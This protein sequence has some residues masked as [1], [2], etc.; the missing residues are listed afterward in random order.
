MTM[1]IRNECTKLALIAL[2]LPTV[3]SAQQSAGCSA[4]PAKSGMFTMTHGDALRNVEVRL[5]AGYD[6]RHPQR[7]VIAFHAWTGGEREFVGEPTVVA[8]SSK[9]GYIL[10]APRGLGAGPPDNKWNGWA[11]RGST[12]GVIDDGKQQ[13]P[14]C[15][16][17]HMPDY[18]YPSCHAKGIAVNTCGW[19][20]CQ[21]DDVGF[22]VD[23][24][25]RLESTLCVDQSHVYAAGGFNGG[26]FAW[27]VGQNPRTAP[28]FRAI[29]SIIGVPHRGDLRP[30]GR[31]GPMPAILITGRA[32][33]VV[34]PGEWDD[35]HFTTSTGN[36]EVGYFAGATAIVQSWSKADNCPVAGKEKPFSTAYASDVDC[37]SYCPANGD[38]WPAV[39]DCRSPLGHVYGWPW[40]WKLVLDFFDRN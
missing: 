22:V 20:H 19:S 39:L 11:F 14:V 28:M 13:L 9:R 37:R 40:S 29:A 38:K 26:M 18:S 2:L 16:P 12:S 4:E 17:A 34:P 33:A 35:P 10:V 36:G 31:P 1:R 27:E 8:E 21:D 30:P 6:G 32:D 23:L 5:P 24:V 25:K 3:A 7:L 15:D